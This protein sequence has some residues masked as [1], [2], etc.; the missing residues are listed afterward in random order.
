MQNATLFA[1]CNAKCNAY[2]N[3]KNTIAKNAYTCE[4]KNIFPNGTRSALYRGRKESNLERKKENE[5][6]ITQYDHQQSSP[7]KRSD[8]EDHNQQRICSQD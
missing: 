8:L 5:N 7:C 2:R 4:Q 3:V 1:K 6:F